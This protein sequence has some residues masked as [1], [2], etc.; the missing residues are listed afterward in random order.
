MATFEEELEAIRKRL[1]DFYDDL[2]WIGKKIYDLI[3]T[4]EESTLKVRLKVCWAALTIDPDDSSFAWNRLHGMLEWRHF[5]YTAEQCEMR[6]KK[7][8]F[9]EISYMA[10]ADRKFPYDIER[11]RQYAEDRA[12][13]M[14]EV[15]EKHRASYR[16]RDNKYFY[17]GQKD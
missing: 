6:G 2:P 5:Q 15:I 14:N 11:L 1:D 9:T 8:A 3:S 7:E 12:K 10:R 13:G 4:W 17:W 16:D